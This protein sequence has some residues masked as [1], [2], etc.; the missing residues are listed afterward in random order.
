MTMQLIQTVTVSSGGSSSIDFVSVP[1]TFTDLY[2]ACS[3]R[4]AQSNVFGIH[5]LRFNGSTA[6]Y[7]GRYLEGNGSSAYQGTYSVGAYLG[8]ST[9]NGAT[10]NTFSNIGA[11]I[12]NYT[13]SVA[14]SVSVDS[15]GENNSTQSFQT[16]TGSLWNVTDPITRVTVVFDGSDTFLQYSSVSLYGIL[17]GSDGIVTVS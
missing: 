6:S 15:V 16:I 17:K 7:S 12:T 3:L 10:A 13:S 8:A 9:G 2:L 11:Y 4:S 1:Q 14:K 5:Y